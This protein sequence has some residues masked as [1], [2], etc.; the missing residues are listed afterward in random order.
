MC[1]PVAQAFMGFAATPNGQA[2]SYATN[3]DVRLPLSSSS[4]VRQVCFAVANQ[5]DFACTWTVKANGKVLA[6]FGGPVGDEYV[7]RVLPPLLVQGFRVEDVTV[8]AS[9]ASGLLVTLEA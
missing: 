1:Q 5:T 8:S 3:A 4:G 9:G 6:V 2:A 7:G